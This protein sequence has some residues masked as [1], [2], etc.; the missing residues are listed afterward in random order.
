MTRLGLRLTLRSGHEAFVRLMVTAA[1]VAIGVM[2]LLSVLAGYHAYQ[3][4]S[5]RACWECTEAAPG[6]P[7]PA[8]SEL[9]NYSE[10]IYKGQFIEE[11]DV[12]ALGAKAP[13]VPG[14]SRL[15]GAGQY[16]ASPALAALIRSVPRD[17][18]GDRFPGSEV[19]TI[20]YQALSGPNELV[21]IIGYS[22]SKL[23]ALPGTVTVDHIATVPD[24]Q[25]TTGIYRLF[26]GIGAIVVLFP[27]LI[28]IN[29]A[30]RLAAT[31]REERF[32]AMR[33]VGATPGQVN[34]IASV[35][36]VVSALLGTLAGIGLFLA[37]RP[38]LADISLSGARFFERTV[39]PTVLGYVVMIVAV[40]A[41]AAIASLWSLRRVRIS[42]LGISRKVTPP[43]PGLWRL[44]P[45]LVGIPLFVV[46]LVTATNNLGNNASS[47]LP[48]VYL[49]TFLIMAGLV[50][51][52]PWLTMQAA[53]V[54][55]RGGTGA[56][57]LLASRRLAD[58]PKGA[59]RT[60]SGLVLAVFVASLIASIIPAFK[61]AESSLGGQAKSLTNVLRAPYSVGPGMGLAPA[62]AAKLVG[63]LET[64]PGRC[65]RPDLLQPALQAEQRASP[66]PGAGRPRP[67]RSAEPDPHPPRSKHHQAQQRHRAQQSQRRQRS[68]RAEQRHRVRQHHQLCGPSRVPRPRRMRA[69]RPSR[70]RKCEQRPVDR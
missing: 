62:S 46:P 43:A 13:L 39:T 12:A 33:L 21:I 41:A 65:A 35:E 7:A 47:I 54:L 64:Y 58:N 9:W 57:S 36:A 61:S 34:V 20:G 14:L 56:S 22:P 31:R 8:R 27:L 29:T 28:L 40:P 63:R 49:G 44:L 25:G 59:F 3:V 50:M 18:L 30:T 55:G 68:H 52:G 53:R 70:L 19:G 2:V 69:R 66:T 23:A 16:Y 1:S 6:S 11:L 38:A 51:S 15:P 45:L 42:P 37:V 10:N 48:F 60:A 32:A 4:T 17:E 24:V 5:N 67:H 26:F